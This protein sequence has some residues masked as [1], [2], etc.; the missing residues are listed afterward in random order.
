MA[1][2]LGNILVVDDF[3]PNRL[4][5][6]L[7]LQQQGHTVETAESGPKALEFLSARPFDLVLLDIVMPGMDGY[8]VL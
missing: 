3:L 4:K 5:L 1:H 6:S 7:S 2:E 8:E